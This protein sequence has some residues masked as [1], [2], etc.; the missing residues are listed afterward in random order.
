MTL[1]QTF[2]IT[3]EKHIGHFWALIRDFTDL[4][5]SVRWSI[6]RL[7]T[8][9]SPQDRKRLILIAAAPGERLPPLPRPTHSENGD[10]QRGIKRF[11]TVA[12][13][14]ARVH[15]GD[16][17]HNL[18]SVNYFHPRRAAYN[19]DRLGYTITTGGSMSHYPDGTRDFTL[20]E[21]ACLQGFPKEH[22]FFGTKTKIKRQIGNAFPSNTVTLLYKHLHAWLLKEDNARE[23]IATTALEDIIVIDDDE[24]R[25]SSEESDVFEETRTS[26]AMDDVEMGDMDVD[27]EAEVIFVG[28]SSTLDGDCIMY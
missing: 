18:D 17:L 26:P 11:N 19:A 22:R 28:T 23:Y 6:V 15:P 9:G 16:D 20:R 4:G 27:T 3:H 1:E 7:C 14:I 13:T 24:P 8:W 12:R 2:G 10:R 21:L 25:S 5:Y